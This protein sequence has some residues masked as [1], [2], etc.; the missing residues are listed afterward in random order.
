MLVLRYRMFPRHRNLRLLLYGRNNI[1]T[2]SRSG[3]SKAILERVQD[4]SSK[5]E[6]ES[7]DSDVEYAP[8]NVPTDSV[9]RDN[10]VLKKRGQ[11]ATNGAKMTAKK[12]AT[13]TMSRELESVRLYSD[14][15]AKGVAINKARAV[16]SRPAIKPTI[17]SSEVAS[18]TR[19]SLVVD[20]KLKR[21]E[22]A[23]H[24]YRMRY[25]PHK[26]LA[27]VIRK[28]GPLRLDAKYRVGT[29]SSRVRTGYDLFCKCC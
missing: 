2:K 18:S 10:S 24:T 13:G 26:C 11:H 7:R 12:P 1:T 20:Q 29:R 22:D 25:V 4:E 3:K 8:S 21:C 14:E 19:P 15:S 16:R 23:V 9:Q 5:A 28:I 27:R 17:A 6:E